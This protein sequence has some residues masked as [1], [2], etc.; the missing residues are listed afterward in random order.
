M[1]RPFALLAT[2]LFVASGAHAQ[3]LNCTVGINRSQLQGDEYVFLDELR[4]DLL[5][6][7]NDRAWTEDVYLD[8]ERIDCSM[9]IV[10]TEALSLSQFRAEIVVRASRPVYG[11]AQPTTL[12]IISDDAWIFNYTRGTTLVYNPDQ[13]NDFISVIDFYVHVILGYDY[14][15]FSPLGGT[16][17]FEQ[18]RRIAER[19]RSNADNVGWGTDFGSERTRFELV[20]EL[21]DPAFIALRRAH[22]AYHYDV[23][24]HFLVDPDTSW[25]E[26][27]EVLRSLNELFLQFNARRYS[28]DVFFTAKYQEI[29]ALFMDAPQKN[30]AYALLSEMDPAH[31]SEYDR[32]VNAR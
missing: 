27:T 16:P 30:E 17:Y 18:A 4:E 7:V 6:Y 20:R 12:F 19:A 3:E 26:A 10:F 23:L 8:R 24:D 28:S 31:L 25:E 13:F 21:L 11:T 14:D 29:A 15:S 32:L 5:R 1:R 2:L 22:F 9:Q